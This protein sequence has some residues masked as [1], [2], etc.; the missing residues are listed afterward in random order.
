MTDK[1]VYAKLVLAT[2]ISLTLTT[3]G[4]YFIFGQTLT[5]GALIASVMTGNV[6]LIG[7]FALFFYI[8]WMSVN[9]LTYKTR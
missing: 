3:L 6:L 7:V 8:S 4:A 1:A 9:M 2:T 5:I